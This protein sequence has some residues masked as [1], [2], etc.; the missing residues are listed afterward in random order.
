MIWLHQSLNYLMFG[1]LAKNLW[2]MHENNY[3]STY[4]LG[5]NE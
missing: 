1:I 4:F 3:F 5:Q 2:K